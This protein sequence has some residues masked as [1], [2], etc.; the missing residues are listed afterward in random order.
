M[1]IRAMICLLLS[2][3]V[4][5]Q[6]FGRLILR[7]ASL[8]RKFNLNYINVVFFNMELKRVFEEYRN[9]FTKIMDLGVRVFIKKF[10]SDNES[11]RLLNEI[12]CQVLY[13]FKGDRVARNLVA[14]TPFVREVIE[15]E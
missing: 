14:G 5:A 13:I 4:D 6:T 1:G 12:G 10:D 7:V 15:L 2:P 3:D 11:L 9:E 8:A